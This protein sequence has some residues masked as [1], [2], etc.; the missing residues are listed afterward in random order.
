MFGGGTQKSCDLQY[1]PPCDLF[2]NR[3]FKD[4]ET[5]LHLLSPSA[6]SDSL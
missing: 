5:T 2:G 6:T 1:L 3:I 4:V